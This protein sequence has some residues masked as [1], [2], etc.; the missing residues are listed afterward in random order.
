VRRLWA[1]PHDCSK[2][3]RCCDHG[4]EHLCCVVWCLSRGREQAAVL[5]M[6]GNRTKG[7][8]LLD[9]FKLKKQE[10]VKKQVK[11]KPCLFVSQMLCLPSCF[12]AAQQ[13][14]LL[15]SHKATV[16]SLFLFL[17]LCSLCGFC[18]V[19]FCVW[20]CVVVCCCGCAA[21]GF[22]WLCGW[23]W[24]MMCQLSMSQCRSTEHRALCHAVE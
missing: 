20:L 21:C 23:T 3:M 17:F 14:V 18:V 11:N 9:D 1:C 13:L 15:Q 5:W 6:V 7:P 12:L 2:Q 10:S 4:K 19:V 8:F 24:D 22:L 16:P